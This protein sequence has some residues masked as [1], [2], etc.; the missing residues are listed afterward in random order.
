M[1]RTVLLFLCLASFF[2]C[3]IEENQ[4]DSGEGGKPEES[5]GPGPSN[6]AGPSVG[7]TFIAAGDNLLHIMVLDSLAEGG[8]YVLDPLYDEIRTLIEKVDIA[9]VNQESLLAG[10]RFG[11]SGYPAFNSPQE[12]GRALVR[13]GFDVI[14]QANNHV[15]DKGY[16]AVFATMDF[17]DGIEGVEYLGIFRSAEERET[18]EVI[19]EKNGIRVGFL[20]YT[21]GTN[22]IPVPKDRP[23]LVA[24]TGTGLMEKDIARLR[25][26]CDFLVV[27]MH[28]GDEYRHD[29]NARQA[30]LAAFL[31]GQGVDLVLGHHPHV[32]QTFEYLPRPDG[33]KTLCFYSL[34]NFISGQQRPPTALGGLA[35]VR[36]AMFGGSLCIEQAGLIPTVTHYER[37]LSG[38]RVYPYYQYSAALAGR[39]GLQ[40]LSSGISRTYFDTILK[41][42]FSDGVILYTPFIPEEFQAAQ[43]AGQELRTGKSEAIP[44]PAKPAFE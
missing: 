25:G 42:L 37:D 36:L 6:E 15:M 38:Y 30:A 29:Y 27:S 8:G 9:F 17:W 10:D 19:I 35:F 1:A 16:A 20:A 13:A 40:Y 23:Y 2:S 33:G 21:E 41:R 24:L 11:I 31:A 26:K 32:L 14:N 5:K 43:G 7:L 12:A 28:W 34:G 4:R 39:H 3:A 18:K 44:G 22:G